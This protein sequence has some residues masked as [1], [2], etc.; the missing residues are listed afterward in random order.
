MFAPSRGRELKYFVLV[1]K[2]TGN[3]FAPSRGRELKSL[4]PHRHDLASGSPPRG[5]GNRNNLA[6]RRAGIPLVRPLAGAGI[7]MGGHPAARLGPAQVRPLTGAGIEMAKRRLPRP[8]CIRFAPSRGR[9][10]KYPQKRHI[11][12]GCKFAPSWG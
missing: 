8:G 12:H 11:Q 7:E 5:G 4:H 9:E 3:T 6:L 10:L 2:I 1:W